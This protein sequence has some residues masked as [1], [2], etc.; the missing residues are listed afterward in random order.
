MNH[1]KD[2]PCCRLY[3]PIRQDPPPL[4]QKAIQDAMTRFQREQP[5]EYRKLQDRLEKVLGIKK[6]PA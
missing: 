4:D 6:D 2:C 5:E 3:G 1:A